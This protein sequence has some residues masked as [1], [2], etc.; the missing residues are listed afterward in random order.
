MDRARLEKKSKHKRLKNMNEFLNLDQTKNNVQIVGIGCHQQN[1]TQTDRHIYIY[2]GRRKPKIWGFTEPTSCF[3]FR[4]FV[5]VYIISDLKQFN[6]L[7]HF[8][9]SQKT[10]TDIPGGRRVGEGTH[11]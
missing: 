1:D 3:L 10:G 2:I 11:I 8:R 9:D 6:A 7:C 4:Q 5:N